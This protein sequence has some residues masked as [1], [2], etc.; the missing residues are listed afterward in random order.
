MINQT[1]VSQTVLTI[2]DKLGHTVYHSERSPPYIAHNT[3]QAARRAG[4]SAISDNC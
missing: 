3:R 4:P 2:T 1:I